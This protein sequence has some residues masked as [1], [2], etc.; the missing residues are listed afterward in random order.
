MKKKEKTAH[1]ASVQK[2]S[3]GVQLNSRVCVFAL[4]AI[5]VTVFFSH[6]HLLCA[7]ATKKLVFSST[8]DAIVHPQPTVLSV[9]PRA[10]II[11]QLSPL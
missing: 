7:E 6:A 1:R 11:H 4:G 5:G 8:F 9:M 3:L 10:Q 2:I